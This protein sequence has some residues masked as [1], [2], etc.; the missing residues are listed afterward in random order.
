MA[1]IPTS[2]KKCKELKCK[3]ST[4]SA[5]RDVVLMVAGNDREDFTNKELFD[6]GMNILNM[7]CEIEPTNIR[8]VSGN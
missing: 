6:Y 8:E 4:F 1:V 3:E 5:N 2:E 7:I